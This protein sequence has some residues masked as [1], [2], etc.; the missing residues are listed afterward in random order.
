MY[1]SAAM[2]QGL[3]GVFD[4]LPFGEILSSDSNVSTHEFMSRVSGFVLANP[5]G[6]QERDSESASTTPSSANT[7]ALSAAG[8]P[9]TPLASPPGAPPSV[10]LVLARERFALIG[11]ALGF[12]A[13]TLTWPLEGW[14]VKALAYVWRDT[15]NR[16]LA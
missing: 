11:G 9:P 4:Y 6:D 14:T 8:P 2:C 15:E 3:L 10:S 13:V 1:E 12:C 7:R 16:G 5:E